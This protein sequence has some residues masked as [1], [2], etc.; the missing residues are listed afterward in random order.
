MP[1]SLPRSDTPPPHPPRSTPRPD[2]PSVPRDSPEAPFARRQLRLF[3]AFLRVGMLGYGGGPSSI[4]LVHKEVVD[5]YKWLDEDEFGDILALGNTL[6]GPIATKMA[7]YIGYR[8]AGPLGMLNAVLSTIVPT[9]FLI[10]VLLTSL[11][12]FSEEPWVQGM[13]KAVVPVVGVMLATLTWQFLERAGA[14]LGWLKAGL[15]LLASLAIIE[16]LG[17]HPGFVIGALLIYALARKPAGTEAAQA[18]GGDSDA[19]ETLEE[20]HLIEGM[21]HPSEHGDADADDLQEALEEDAAQED[22]ARED[23]IP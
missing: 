5:G 22:A 13:T 17:L 19:G 10:V 23:E 7:G 12:T 18:G 14:G 2:H 6:P 8:V 21:R 11:A 16:Y 3:L 1:S 20:E 4:P 9:I 15:L